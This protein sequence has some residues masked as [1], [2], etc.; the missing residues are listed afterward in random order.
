MPPLDTP[1]QILPATLVANA[2]PAHPS[3]SIDGLRLEV[4]SPKE[5]S[6]WG[7]VFGVDTPYLMVPT[8]W[9]EW[10]PLIYGSGQ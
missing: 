2:R 4:L 6:Y 10:I 5:A 9:G 3:P 7:H 8:G 1:Q